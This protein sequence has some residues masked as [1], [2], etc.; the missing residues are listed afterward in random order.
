MRPVLLGA[1][2]LRAEPG[3]VGRAQERIRG[4]VARV[5]SACS[6]QAAEQHRVEKLVEPCDQ[7]RNQAVVTPKPR[8]NYEP[9]I[10][11]SGGAI[12]TRY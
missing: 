7:E 8:E 4:D 10:R 2:A 1:V 9:V 11:V 6:V 5:A 12:Q 3:G